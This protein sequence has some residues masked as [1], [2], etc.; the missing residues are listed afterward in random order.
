VHTCSFSLPGGLPTAD[1]PLYTLAV[2]C[3]TY[4]PSVL[5]SKFTTCKHQV[6]LTSFLFF[7]A[8]TACHW[9]VQRRLA[10][11]VLTALPMEHGRRGMKV[12]DCTSDANIA[13]KSCILYT[14]IMIEGH[15][16]EGRCSIPA[17]PSESSRLE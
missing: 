3:T 6:T 10:Q 14:L 15:A 2:E 13:T 1:P 4:C 7:A 9:V 12:F 17:G 11:V 5:V 16:C 8:P